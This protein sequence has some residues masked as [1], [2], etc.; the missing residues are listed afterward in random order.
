MTIEAAFVVNSRT[1]TISKPRSWHSKY[2]LQHGKE[3][4]FLHDI[5][6]GDRE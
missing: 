1:S 3:I 2:S 6:F 5:A 4:A